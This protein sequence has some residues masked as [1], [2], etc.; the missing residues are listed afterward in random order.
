MIFKNNIG[1]YAGAGSVRHDFYINGVIEEPED[2][3]EMLQILHTASETDVVYLHLNTPGGNFAAACQI[4]DAIMQSKAGAVIACA[5]GEVCS[6]GTMI[7]LACN[8]WHVSPFATFMF[9]TSSGGQI[10]KM[11]DTL[12]QAKAHEEHL[13]R[14]CGLLYDPFFDADEID[15][16]INHNQDLWLTPEEVTERLQLM[17]KKFEEDMKEAEEKLADDIEA[18]LEEQIAER[19]AERVAE[20]LRKVTEELDAEEAEVEVEK[21]KRK[22]KTATKKD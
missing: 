22:R 13:N 8:G 15:E 20:E 17:S 10:G 21:P 11:P 19:V 4:C 2:Y 12:K 6:A 9:H 7:F 14:V 3:N 16:I 1:W 5:E 18:Q